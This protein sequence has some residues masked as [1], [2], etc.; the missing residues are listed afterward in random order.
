MLKGSWFLHCL[1]L[2]IRQLRIRSA[3]SDRHHPSFWLSH[4]HL[5]APSCIWWVIFLCLRQCCPLLPV[6]HFAAA[7]TQWSG[8][9]C[10]S[11][12]SVS[13]PPQK[14]I[15]VNVLWCWRV[16]CV[17]DIKSTVLPCSLTPVCIPFCPLRSKLPPASVPL[18][19]ICCLVNVVLIM[20]IITME[21][22][23]WG[24][25][26]TSICLHW[27]CVEI[28]LLIYIHAH[29]H[30]HTHTCANTNFKQPVSQYGIQQNNK[31]VQ[32]HSFRMYW[33]M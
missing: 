4:T 20:V 26:H 1:L 29:T 10:V 25:R 23:E 15:V 11:C 31:K 8:V 2:L 33:H 21:L 28:W 5:A 27:N 24:K 22:R 14:N 32:Q 6:C 19:F 18:H 12:S 7:I 9:F 13:T 3:A 16:L 30:A 17:I